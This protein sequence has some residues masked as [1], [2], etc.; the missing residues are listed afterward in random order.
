MNNVIVRFEIMRQDSEP[1]PEV[2]TQVVNVSD[3]LD[4]TAY[5]FIGFGVG[6]RVIL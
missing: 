3:Q 5:A 4:I 1:R 2:A 6:L